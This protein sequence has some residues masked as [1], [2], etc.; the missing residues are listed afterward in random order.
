MGRIMTNDLTTA[1]SADAD[2]S[3]APEHDDIIARRIALD[4][5]QAEIVVQQRILA[6]LISQVRDAETRLAELQSS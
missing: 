4:D 6:D 1:R 3:G 5:L 2:F